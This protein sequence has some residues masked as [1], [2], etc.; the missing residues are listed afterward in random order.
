MGNPTSYIRLKFAIL[1]AFFFFRSFF[2]KKH[3]DPFLR[4]RVGVVKGVIREVNIVVFE[5][6]EVLS[7][8]LSVSDKASVELGKVKNGGE[9]TTLRVQ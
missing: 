5:Q 2:F 3:L 7:I 8:E 1:F 9:N 6:V 4:E